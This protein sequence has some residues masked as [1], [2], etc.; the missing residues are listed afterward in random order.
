MVAPPTAMTLEEFLRLPEEKPY[1][2]YEDGVVTPK[3]SPKAE[4]SV[5]Q[6]ELASLVNAIVRPT[7]A[8]RVFTELRTTYAGRSLVPD[9]SV[10][11]IERIALDG[12]GRPVS[13]VTSPPDIAV[14]IRSHGQSRKSLYNRCLWYVAHGVKVAVLVDDRD[15]SVMVFRPDT[16][17]LAAESDDPIDLSDVVPGLTFTPAELFSALQ[18]A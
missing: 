2:E 14:E 9:V 10:Y 12:R 3:M 13:D 6:T 18:I 7:R 17:P 1:L 15:E 16:I 11:R 8:G 5:L 4:D